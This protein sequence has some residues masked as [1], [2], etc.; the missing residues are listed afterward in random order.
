MVTT[1]PPPVCQVIVPLTHHTHDD[2]RPEEDE[3]H[4]HLFRIQRK[5]EPSID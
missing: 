5:V 4:P 1:E 2:D 3:I